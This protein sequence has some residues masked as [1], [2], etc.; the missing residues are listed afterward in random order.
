MKPYQPLVVELLRRHNVKTILDAP[1]GSGWLG[2]SM[3]GHC[4]LDGLDLYCAS[5]PHY[6]RFAAHDLNTGFP[7]DFGCYDAIVT[8]E[9]IEHLLAPALF[10]RAAWEHLHPSGLLIV[11]TPNVWYPGAKLQYLLR[12]FFP[13]F[14]SL[15]GKIQPGSHMHLSPCSF[16]QLYLLL[17]LSGFVNIQ[18]HRTAGAAPKHFYEKILGFPQAMYCRSKRRH[19]GSDEE[20]TFW[21]MAGSPASLYARGLVV[22]AE[23]GG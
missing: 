4:L 6:N 1:S 20:R 11:T 19:A 8:C 17:S 16:P 2:E 5:S 3:A 15:V 22:S 18:L 21:E 14:P 12:G 7:A 23:K 13:G 9:G 10:L